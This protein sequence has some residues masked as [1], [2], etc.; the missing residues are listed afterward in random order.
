MWSNDRGALRK[1]F[2]S[3]WRRFRNREPLTGE[4]GLVVEALLAHPEY[5]PLVEQEAETLW[6]DLEP[7]PFLHLS[8]HIALSEQLGLDRPSG[9]KAVFERLRGAGG[10]PHKAQHLMMEC[11]AEVLWEAQ[12]QGRMPDE[13]TYIRRLH[14]LAGPRDGR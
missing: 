12:S 7:N 1:V 14:E 10:D 8:L 13:G 2:F 4:E 5:Q 6:A 3:G 11:L 9:V